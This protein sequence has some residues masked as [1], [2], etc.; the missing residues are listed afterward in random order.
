MDTNTRYG[1]TRP[2]RGLSAR[3][4]DSFRNPLGDRTRYVRGP[5][6]VTV[7]VSRLICCYA[8][9]RMVSVRPVPRESPFPE[10][11]SVP[12]AP[13]EKSLTQ[14]GMRPIHGFSPT[15][16]IAESANIRPN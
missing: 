16:T 9:N 6:F 4:H 11:L 13:I 15:V 5:L 3:F 7:T 14:A 12:F 2:K 8:E 1:C 10:S